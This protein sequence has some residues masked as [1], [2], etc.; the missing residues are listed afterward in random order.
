MRSHRVSIRRTQLSASI[1]PHFAAQYASI[2]E[3][4]ATAV[5]A[6]IDITYMPTNK[7]SFNMSIHFS[8]GMSYNRSKQLTFKNSHLQSIVCSICCSNHRAVRSAV[9]MSYNDSIFTT[10]LTSDKCSYQCT[11]F[12]TDI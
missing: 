11:P 4:F 7:S 8:I 1:R 10:R 9:N 2:L 12:K 5:F 3:T 6:S